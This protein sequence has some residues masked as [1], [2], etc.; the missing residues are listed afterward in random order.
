VG[1]TRKRES[2][3]LIGL[4]KTIGEV[5][6]Q[7]YFVKHKTTPKKQKKKKKKKKKKAVESHTVD[8]VSLAKCS[9]IGA[10]PALHAGFS[11]VHVP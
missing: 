8:G 2:H 4:V 6:V 3:R 7:Y 5:G 10:N 9:S 1:I 11:Q